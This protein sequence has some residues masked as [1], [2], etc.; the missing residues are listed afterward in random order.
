MLATSDVTDLSDT[1]V[2]QPRPT[3]ASLG[4]SCS[5]PDLPCGPNA[6]WS[7]ATCPDINASACCIPQPAL[8]LGLRCAQHDDC[9]SGHCERVDVGL[10]VCTLHCEASSGG[11]CPWT[12]ECYVPGDSSG[13]CLPS[14]WA[15]EPCPDNLRCVSG[16]CEPVYCEREPPVGCCFV[17]ADCG[18]R[19]MCVGASCEAEEPGRCLPRPREGQ[20]WTDADCLYPARRCVGAQLPTEACETASEEAMGTCAQ[21]SFPAVGEITCGYFHCVAEQQDCLDCVF[22]ERANPRCFDRGGARSCEDIG[23]TGAY[24]MACDGSEDCAENERCVWVSE[25][26]QCATEPGLVVCH[27]DADCDEGESC[28]EQEG[29]GFDPAPRTCQP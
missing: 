5:G 16:L 12:A 2:A 13:S 15:G 17:D 1:D 29:T 20:C 25:G 6:A 14:C 11:V 28:L 8:G 27:S 3:C 22:E 19:A 26:S 9:E 21:E 24:T 7:P 4:G 18:E 23:H 10:S